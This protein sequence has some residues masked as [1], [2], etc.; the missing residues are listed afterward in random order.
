MMR[1]NGAPSWFREIRAEA[2]RLYRELPWPT[3]AEEEWRRSDLSKL[4]LDALVGA[5]DRGSVDDLPAS[6]TQLSADIPTALGGKGLRFLDLEDAASSE[7]GLLRP[8][9][10]ARLASVGDRFAALSLAFGEGG[11][12]VVPAGFGAENRGASRVDLRTSARGPASAL[13]LFVSAGAD[14]EIEIAQRVS[15]AAEGGLFV[16]YTG[17]GLADAS[18]VSFR[19]VQELSGTALSLRELGS[20]L[21]SGARLG[22][23]DAELG[24]RFARSRA[25][26]SLAGSDAEARL[27]G[28]FHCRPGV[29][30]DL[31]TVQ[32]HG[33]PRCTSRA[34]YKGAV[35]G[36][37]QAVFRGLIEVAKGASGTDAFLANRN[38]LLGEG[39]RADSLPTLR[40]GDND[41][42]CSHGSTT[43]RLS[44]DELF[45]LGTR[46]F[47][48]RE[49]REFLL[50]GW[51]EEALA[52]SGPEYSEALLE[53]LR[54]RLGDIEEAA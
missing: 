49:A 2:L 47:G 28:I 17:L 3:T 33:A 29:R 27:D 32:L 39:A 18:R 45:Y 37:G 20:T 4:G 44:E 31:S 1:T 41:V 24:A 5:L 8:L 36:G 54:G 43:G 25:L 26:C 9:L 30:F 35:E 21:G 42:R 53:D 34:L 13:L 46:G 12:L 38:L 11:L 10:E 15:G 50:L 6:T 19:E 51:F 40:I 52:A 23:L 14:S 16:S 22:H 48:R 7:A